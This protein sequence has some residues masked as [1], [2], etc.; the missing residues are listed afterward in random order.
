MTN[1]T[2]YPL[3]IR[4]AT[5]LKAVLG[6]SVSIYEDLVSA[7]DAYVQVEQ[8]ARIYVWKYGTGKR[9]PP[10][11]PVGKLAKAS[12]QVTFV[13]YYLKNYQLME[14]FAER[15]SMDKSTA[16]KHLSFLLVRLHEV[17][18]EW[19]VLP[20]RSFPSPEAMQAYM[21]EQNWDEIFIDVTER[22]HQRPKDQTAQQALY[23]GKKKL[24]E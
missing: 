6:V 7:F 11:E 12:M 24:M 17:L 20:H 15:F 19:S 18:T 13:L 3:N 23:S 21:D 16:S 4:N 2:K 8:N 10:A 14:T 5:Q 9:K 1:L 22:R